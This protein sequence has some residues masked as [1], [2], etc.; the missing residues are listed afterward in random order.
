MRAV[1][2]TAAHNDL[3]LG[4]GAVAD[5]RS[6][7]D[8]RSPIRYF[9]EGDERGAARLLGTILDTVMQ[10]IALFDADLNL[11]LFNRSYPELLDYAPDFLRLGMNYEEILRFNAARRER[12]DYDPEQYLQDRLAV[13]QSLTPSRREHVRP[14][15]KVIAIRFTPIPGGGFVNRSEEHTV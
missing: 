10:G 1:P 3:P 15:G 2:P 14:T 11:V 12:G 6:G 5:S 4:M 8:D 7:S 13:V 9:D